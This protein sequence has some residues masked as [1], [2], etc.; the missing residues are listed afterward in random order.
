MS[1]NR[2]AIDSESTTTKAASERATAALVEI[3]KSKSDFAAALNA[4]S[5]GAAAVAL[6]KTSAETALAATQAIQTQ[7]SEISVKVAKDGAAIAKIETD[8]RSL[9]DSLSKTVV[10]TKEAQERVNA[11]EKNWLN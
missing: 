7:S 11:Y 9:F 1:E 2:A 3:E 6:S 10:S 4:V 8:S 5:N